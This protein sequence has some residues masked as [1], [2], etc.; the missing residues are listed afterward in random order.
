MTQPRIC[1]NCEHFQTN[2]GTP[3]GCEYMG[4]CSRYPPTP[5]LMPQPQSVMTGP[6]SASVAMAG[7][8]PP[9]PATYSCGEWSPLDEPLPTTQ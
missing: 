6:A 1:E 5:M 7:V 9:V 2:P 8:S 3:A 4:Q